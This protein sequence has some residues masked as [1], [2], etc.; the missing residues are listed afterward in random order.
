MNSWTTFVPALSV[1]TTL[2]LVAFTGCG[3]PNET[4]APPKPAGAT[5]RGST[6]V[7]EEPAVGSD[8][9]DSAEAGGGSGSR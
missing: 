5:T 1:A 9:R 6:S 7:S 4:S 3:A 8:S 2:I